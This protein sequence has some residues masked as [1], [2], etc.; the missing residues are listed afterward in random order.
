MCLNPATG[1]ARHAP[2]LNCEA[3]SKAAAFSGPQHVDR[4]IA[5][6]LVH[7]L[8]KLRH[9]RDYEITT[10]APEQTSRG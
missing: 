9:A 8:C 10:L 6:G 5:F 2:Q 4:L 3:L 7:K 1:L